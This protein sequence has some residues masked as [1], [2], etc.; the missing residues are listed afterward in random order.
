MTKYGKIKKLASELDISKREATDLLRR[1]KY[2][3]NDA[4]DLYM[5]DNL[6]LNLG[7]INNALNCIYESMRRLGEIVAEAFEGIGD[8]IS[9]IMGD[10]ETI[11]NIEK[12]LADSKEQNNETDD[13]KSGEQ[14]AKNE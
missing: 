9:R 8:V 5:I 11:A 4:R 2:D 12:L 6:G 1:A 3:L 14:E 7:V 10:K 13:E